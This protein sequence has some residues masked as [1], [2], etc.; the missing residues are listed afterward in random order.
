MADITDHKISQAEVQT[1]GVVSAPDTLTTSATESKK[2]FDKLPAFIVT[3]YNQLIDYIKSFYPSKAEVN[4]AINQR[5]VEI[6]SSDMQKAVYDPSNKAIDIFKAFTNKNL[7]INWDFANPVNQRGK[8][9]YTGAVYGIDRWKGIYGGEKVEIEN[10]RIKCTFE[11]NQGIKQVFENY[12]QL[13][14]KTVTLSILW[15]S[16]GSNYFGT[17]VNTNFGAAGL[18]SK[19]STFGKSVDSVTVTIPQ[20]ITELNVS[21]TGD[22]SCYVYGVK[23]ELGSVS[24]L[25]QDAPAD[26]G[27]QLALCQRYYEVMQPFRIYK[28]ARA[29][30]SMATEIPKYLFKVTK[31]AIPTV[32]FKYKRSDG[33]AET[34]ATASHPSSGGFVDS[35]IAFECDYVDF[36]DIVADA[37]L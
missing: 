35:T 22:G 20:N 21:I 11:N 19:T 24:T 2:I 3:K 14:G 15:E 37:E 13:A 23:L 25:A 16:A 26:Y 31:R 8:P 34:P 1:N 29:Q 9:S 5:I 17:A 36:I 30:W 4:T 18:I 33:G 10:G 6:G 27:E 32:S 7:I 12:K 28:G